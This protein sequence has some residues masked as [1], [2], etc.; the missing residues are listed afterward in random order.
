MNNKMTLKKL[1]KIQLLEMKT[2]KMKLK[3]MQLLKMETTQMKFLKIQT[4]KMMHNRYLQ[5]HLV[6][7]GSSGV[8]LRLDR[9]L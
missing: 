7:G 4:T 6:P 1:M 3:K 5:N 9:Y 2:P 8:E